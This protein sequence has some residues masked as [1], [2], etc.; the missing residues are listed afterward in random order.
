M[1]YMIEYITKKSAQPAKISAKSQPLAWIS[2][3]DPSKTEIDDLADKFDL[4][5][6]TLRDVLDADEIPR[7]EHIGDYDYIFA[8]FAVRTGEYNISTKPILTIMNEKFIMTIAP[9]R[10][11]V[12]DDLLSAN[13]R[14]ATDNANA[15]LLGLLKHI[16]DNYSTDIKQISHRIR[17]ATAHLRSHKLERDDFVDFVLIEDDLSNIL[18]SLTPMPPILKRLADSRE[19]TTF[20]KQAVQTFDDITLNIEQSVNSCNSNMRRIV[21][22]REAYSTISNNSLNRSM[23][24]LTKLT[25]LVAL[26]NVVFGMYGMNVSLPGQG[27]P[28]IYAVIM[29]STLILVIFVFAIAKIRHLF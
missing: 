9:V 19:T 6:D 3:T 18:S 7:L 5:R 28:E 4:D 14:F 8:R 11:P 16:F 23:K 27:T 12:F 13:S 20:A 10:P 15:V 25:L 22:V 17:S 24:T 1:I 21:S 26:P 29:I 2:V